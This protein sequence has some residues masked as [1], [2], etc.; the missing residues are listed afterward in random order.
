[1]WILVRMD[2]LILHVLTCIDILQHRSP[3][4]FVPRVPFIYCFYYDC[5]TSVIQLMHWFMVHGSVVIIHDCIT[6]TVHINGCNSPHCIEVYKV[7]SEELITSQLLLTYKNMLWQYFHSCIIKTIH[8][9]RG[10]HILYC[11]IC[12]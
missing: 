7:F 10:K 3:K 5:I 11:T 12:F 6:C 9:L 8:I 4:Y 2:M 1:M